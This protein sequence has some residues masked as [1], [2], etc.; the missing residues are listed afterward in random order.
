M[1]DKFLNNCLNKETFKVEA[2]CKKINNIIQISNFSA[3]Y[4]NM[5]EISKKL[6]LNIGIEN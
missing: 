4:N 3:Y 6:D 2:L 5:N 1:I